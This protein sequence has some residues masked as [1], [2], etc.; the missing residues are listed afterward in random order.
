MTPHREK[1]LRELLAFY[2]EAGVD[3][4]LG[5]QPV[6]R[7]G[8]PSPGGG[9]SARPLAGEPGWGEATNTERRSFPPAALKRGDPLPAGGERAAPPPSPEAAVMAAREAARSAPSL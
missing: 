2:A 5:E 6:N 8:E 3:A 1:A 7:F 4:L 9:G